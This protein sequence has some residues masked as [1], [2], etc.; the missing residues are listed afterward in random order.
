MD[1]DARVARRLLGLAHRA[2]DAVGHVVN[3]FGLRGGRGTP[4]GHEDG[5]AVVIAVPAARDVERAPPD[6]DGAGRHQLVEDLTARTRYP[7]PGG[8]SV[9]LAEP[10]VQAVPVDPEALTGTVV[11]A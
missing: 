2:L 1:H 11:G 10:V 3:P 5:D 9:G 6:D 8:A 7:K 4:R